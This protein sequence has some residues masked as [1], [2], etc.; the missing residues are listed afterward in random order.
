MREELQSRVQRI[1][2]LACAI[3]DDIG[4]LEAEEAMAPAAEIAMRRLTSAVND[5][6]RQIT[7][8]DITQDDWN[9]YRQFHLESSLVHAILQSQRILRSLR[10]KMT[11]GDGLQG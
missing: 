7:D 1:Q 3:Q 5:I 2:N 4:V 8:L 11:T 6:D 9:P 10:G